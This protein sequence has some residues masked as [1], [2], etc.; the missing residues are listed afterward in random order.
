MSLLK[1]EKKNQKTKKKNKKTTPLGKIGLVDPKGP[2][3]QINF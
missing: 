1:E 3:H 2:T